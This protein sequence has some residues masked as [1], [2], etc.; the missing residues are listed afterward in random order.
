VACEYC[1]TEVR[2][3]PVEPTTNERVDTGESRAG[4]RGAALIATVLAVLVLV[5][6]A[7]VLVSSAASNE[8]ASLALPSA[9]SPAPVVD[10]PIREAVPHIE[11]DLRRWD[12]EACFMA[13]VTADGAREIG[14]R[15]T[16]GSTELAIPVLV[17]GAT[18]SV[19]WRGE[20]A[21]RSSSTLF[22][23]DERHFG[24]SLKNALSVEIY[25]ISGPEP[26]IRRTLSDVLDEFGVG[27]DCI[28]LRSEDGHV[29]RLSLE[30]GSAAS[31]NARPDHRL[32]EDPPHIECS[33]ISTLRRARTATDG[34]LRFELRPRRPGTPF[35]V[36]RGL[37][38]QTELWKQSLRFVPVG[39]E[40]IGCVALT[41]APGIVITIGSTRGTDNE[42]SLIGLDAQTGIERYA[43]VQPPRA[44]ASLRGFGFNGR[45]VILSEHWNDELVAFDPSTGREVWR[46]GGR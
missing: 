44:S 24:L 43:I 26:R 25:A 7:Q 34:D 29:V 16:D 5:A 15:I 21:E 38:G 14:G 40:A 42:L 19:L 33:I 30:D 3:E 36:V 39:G 28:S 4:G 8:R 37:R 9:P 20:P 22:C 13:D 1:G 45:F 17:D 31:C 6:V 23:V 18:G 10:P 32:T 35:L 12:S 41:A 11:R 2:F 46:I 27:D